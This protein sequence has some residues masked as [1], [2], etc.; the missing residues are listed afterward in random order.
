MSSISQTP[1]G[2]GV[3]GSSSIIQANFRIYVRSI[4]INLGR[5]LDR[6]FVIQIGTALLIS[7]AV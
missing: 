6:G 5:A 7:N 4:A 1:A 3:R 2:Q